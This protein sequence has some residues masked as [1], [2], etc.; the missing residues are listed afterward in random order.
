MSFQVYFHISPVGAEP[1]RF[2]EGQSTPVE[3]PHIQFQPA[4]ALLLRPVPDKPDHFAGS[5][6]P[7]AVFIHAEFVDVQEV[8][9]EHKGVRSFQ[10][11]KR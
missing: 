1:D 2:I 4:E 7:P 3:R 9:L 10:M 8:T 5:A 6:L 11:V